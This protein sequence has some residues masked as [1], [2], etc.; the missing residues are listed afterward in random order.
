MKTQQHSN[1]HTI[2]DIARI[3]ATH[4]EFF[5]TPV[6]KHEKTLS[7][8][9]LIRSG[10]LIND[11]NLDVDK[12]EILLFPWHPAHPID[13]YKLQTYQTLNAGTV[14][15]FIDGLH[16]SNFAPLGYV[17]TQSAVNSQGNRLLTANLNKQ[18][19]N[20]SVRFKVVVDIPYSA[21]D[22]ILAIYLSGEGTGFSGK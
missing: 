17:S 18:K 10:L 21:P 16:V 2:Y 5:V 20:E 22:L 1:R 13:D 19:L 8:T 3:M 14:S 4:L 11:E 7:Q 9:N 12:I 15:L 6:G